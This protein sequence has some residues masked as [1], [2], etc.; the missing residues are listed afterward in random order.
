[1]KIKYHND[2]RGNFGDDLNLVFFNDFINEKRNDLTIYGIGTLLNNVHGTIKNSVIIGA[3]YG[4]GESLEYDKESTTILGVRGPITAMKMD[5]DPGKYVIGDPAL[6]VSRMTEF[7]KPL[8]KKYKKVIALHHSTAE[9]FDYHK[10]KCGDYYFLDPGLETIEDYIEIIRGAEEIYT[11]SLHG[12][13]ISAAFGKPFT[14]ISMIT[15]LEQKKWLDFY[16]SVGINELDIENV[17]VPKKPLLRKIMVTGKFR[18][19]YN[20]SVHGIKVNESA[21]KYTVND[22]E[23]K[24]LNKKLVLADP[25][26]VKSLQDKFE[27]ALNLLREIQV[28]S[29]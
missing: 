16:N 11:E 7:N 26:R 5:L 2:W 3:G 24:S 25:S 8:T 10:K 29:H 14:A 17:Y 20:T 4:Y 13:I 22:I 12:A 15:N 28:S 18:K 6:Y 23:N 9:L 19:I 21:L 27:N 1:M